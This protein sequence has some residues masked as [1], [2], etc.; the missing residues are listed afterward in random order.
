MG[1]YQAVIDT[2]VTWTTLIVGALFMVG[3]SVF[4][5]V[6]LWVQVKLLLRAIR[7]Y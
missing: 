4:A 6:Y 3:S 7:G 5:V 2:V 1:E